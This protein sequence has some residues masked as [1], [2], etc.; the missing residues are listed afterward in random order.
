MVPTPS[1][2]V[3][4]ALPAL[5]VGERLLG[6]LSGLT[7]VHLVGGAVRDLLLGRTPHELD[8]VAEEDGPGVAG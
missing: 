4:A 1:D 8:L 6:A 3:L 5:P 7:G 2:R